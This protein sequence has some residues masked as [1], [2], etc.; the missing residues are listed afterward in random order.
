[1]NAIESAIL[2]LITEIRLSLDYFTTEYNFYIT[3][4]L[5]T[6][7]S[8]LLNGIEDLFAKNL[9]IKV[10]RWQPINAFQLSGSVDAK[11]TEQNF[12]RLTVALGLGLTAAN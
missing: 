9:D 7:G 2:N 11:A 3:K 10:E 8:S 4:I 6:G 5:L 1:M 12:S